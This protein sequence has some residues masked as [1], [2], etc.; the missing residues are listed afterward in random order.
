M[1]MMLE[2][3]GPEIQLMGAVQQNQPMLIM[4][5]WAFGGLSPTKPAGAHDAGRAGPAKPADAHDAGHGFG[6]GD[7]T[8]QLAPQSQLMLIM[9]EGAGPEIQLMGAVQQNQLMLITLGW[10]LGA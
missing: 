7:P 4:L 3:A 1:L 6:C 10:A 8:N 5:G 2:G 9:L